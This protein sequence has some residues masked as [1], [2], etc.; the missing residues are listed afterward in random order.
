MRVVREVGRGEKGKGMLRGGKVMVPCG[1]CGLDG[2][3]G[4]ARA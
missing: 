3:M 2:E 4:E 1:A